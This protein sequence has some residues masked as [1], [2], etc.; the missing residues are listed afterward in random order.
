MRRERERERESRHCV[1][2]I[3]SYLEYLMCHSLAYFDAKYCV[4]LRN[5]YCI[6][7]YYILRD[8]DTITMSCYNGQFFSIILSSHNNTDKVY[9]HNIVPCSEY[10]MILSLLCSPCPGLAIYHDKGYI[11]LWCIMYLSVMSIISNLPKNRK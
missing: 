8:T 2:N 4:V 5:C 9:C 1:S 7:Q 11:V 10:W 3:L 6:L